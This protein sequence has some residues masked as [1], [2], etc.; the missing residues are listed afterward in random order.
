MKKLLLILSSFAG[1]MLITGCGESGPTLSVSDVQVVAPA[2]GRKASVAYLTIHNN[3]GNPVDLTSISSPQFGRVELHETTLENGIARMRALASISVDANASIE[4]APGGK[5][6]MLFEPVT[7]LLP[8]SS[9]S[10][11]LKFASEA[12]L[13]VQTPLKTRLSI[14]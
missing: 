5:H 13:I 1:L 12:T 14:D 8:G 11:Q 2:P 4:L 10:L 6:V 9:V 7:A 3:D